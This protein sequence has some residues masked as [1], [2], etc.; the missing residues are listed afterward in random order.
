MINLEGGVG[1]PRSLG[2][3]DSNVLSGKLTRDPSAMSGGPLQDGVVRGALPGVNGEQAS[4]SGGPTGQRAGGL[5]LGPIGDLFPGSSH[6]GI[7]F[8]H[9]I[10]KCLSLTAYCFG[11]LVFGG[12]RGDSDFVV[13]FV[14][15]LVLLSLDFWTVK[16][17]SG[18][19]L[20]GLCWQH[21][22]AAD[23]VAEWVFQKAPA[24][25]RIGSVDYRVFWGGVVV[26]AL[27]WVALCINT[28]VS[29][30]L[31]WVSILL[32]VTLSLYCYLSTACTTSASYPLVFAI[33][34]PCAAGSAAAL[35][36]AAAAAGVAAPSLCLFF[37]LQ[38]Y[39]PAVFAP[40][41]AADSTAV[42]FCPK[43]ARSMNQ[44]RAAGAAAAAASAQSPQD[45]ALASLQAATW[46]H[47]PQ[48]QRLDKTTIDLLQ[49]QLLEDDEFADDM[50][51]LLLARFRAK[52]RSKADGAAAVASDGSSDASDERS[53]TDAAD[54]CYSDVSREDVSRLKKLGYELQAHERLLSKGT[55]SPLCLCCVFLLLSGHFRLLLKLEELKY[56]PPAGLRRVPFV[57]TLA[58]VAGVDTATGAAD[59]SASRVDVAED[60]KREAAFFAQL[61]K[62]VPVALARLR[63]LGLQFSRPPDFLAEMLKSDQQMGR[64]RA[65]I[66]AEQEQQRQF[67]AKRNQRLNK[68]FNKLSGHHI[69]REQEEARRRNMQLRAIDQWKKDRQTAVRAGTA[70]GEA[71]DE[72]DQWLVGNERE[73]N[74]ITPNHGHSFKLKGAAGRKPQKTGAHKPHRRRGKNAKVK[75]LSSSNSERRKTGQKRKRGGH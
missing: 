56:A 60:L 20:V 5:L 49:E 24:D 68:R 27:V 3:E 37:L 75:G 9:I 51:A 39:I 11:S 41:F 8:F 65:R 7:C 1:P 69:V 4:G 30:D 25:R 33:D 32:R 36:S 53:S 71:E 57:E 67:E 13:T 42:A 6:P 73:Q 15:T 28:I 14:L 62:T 23:G 34:P 19:K 17:I 50:R 45:V 48:Q 18:R 46:R 29:L 72:F 31:L 52:H 44:L 38:G 64:I 66:D 47:Q 59:E 70:V 63:A 54:V 2:E 55:Y 58:V 21:R 40:A 16:N 74:N 26:W 22:V 35:I 61:Q 43:C 12:A 10:F